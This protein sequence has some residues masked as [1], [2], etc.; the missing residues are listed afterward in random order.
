ML[1]YMK[2]SALEI[3]AL[4]MRIV[5]QYKAQTLT[6]AEIGRMSKV[7][8]SQVYRICTGKFRTISNNVVQVC[9]VLGVQVETVQTRS[10][11]D[12]PSWRRLEMSLRNLWDQTPKG[13]KRIIKILDSMADWRTD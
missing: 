4:K 6:Y 8:Q 1:I 7:D 12:D 13:A 3:G 10:G 2:P 9:K 11:E 5:E